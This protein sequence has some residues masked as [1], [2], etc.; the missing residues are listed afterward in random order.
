[1]KGTGA[2]VAERV[3]VAIVGARV[4]GSALAARLADTGMSVALFDREQPS[5]PSLSTHILHG[6]EDLRIE[7][8]FDSLLAAGVPALREVH[9]R[10]DDVVFR[11]DHNRD[12]GLCPRREILDQVMLDRAVAAGARTYTHTPVVGLLGSG[13][14]ERDPVRGLV[15]QRSDGSVR[16][17]LAG[18]VVGAD[19]RNSTVARGVHARQYLTSRSERALIWRYFRG[20]PLAPALH[21]H[22][23]GVHIVSTLPTG[24]DELVLITQPP[25]DLLASPGLTGL[26]DPDPTSM[27]QHVAQVSAPIGELVRSA[28]PAGPTRRIVSYPCYFRQPHGPGWALI[29]DA[30]HAKDATVGQGINDALRN[31]RGLADVL[32]QGWL[33]REDLDHRLRAWHL[34]RDRMEM[35]NYWYGQDLGRA[36]PISAMERAVLLELQRRERGVRDLDDLMADRL[37]ADRVLTLP[38][39]LRA[40]G[41]RL[42]SEADARRV[43]GQ[44]AGVVGL[45]RRRARAAARQ[46]ARA[47][48]FRGA[49]SPE[50]TAGSPNSVAAA[51]MAD[52]G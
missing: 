31:A 41:G 21:W 19:G 45:A 44:A 52:H 29:G 10:I 27:L 7:G 23:Q 9:V 3:D 2:G 34:E 51:G 50:E 24:P 20:R 5:R 22:R 26:S 48:Q 11:F 8:I 25:A 6:T 43:I 33:D 14:N 40:M 1:M 30:G 28:R 47:P 36:G 39:L 42:G 32:V 18:V 15:A 37:S 46:D 12:P 16:E 35:A 13:T 17:V 38:R 4:A 49:V